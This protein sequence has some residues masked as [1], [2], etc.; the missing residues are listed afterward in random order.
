MPLLPHKGRLVLNAVIEIALSEGPLSGRA[1]AVRLGVPHRHLEQIMF[2]LAGNGILNG[3][4]GF[5]G[6]YELTLGAHLITAYDVLWAANS[7]EGIGS[8]D[9]GGDDL[10]ELAEKVVLPAVAQAEQ[11]FAAALMRITIEDL[12]QSSARNTT[13]SQAASDVA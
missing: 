9:P 4:R 12:I 11:S 10:S 8:P 13:T 7:I 1:L 3:I 6:G 5:R 2:A